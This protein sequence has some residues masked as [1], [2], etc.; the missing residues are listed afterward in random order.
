MLKEKLNRWTIGAS[1][2]WKSLNASITFSEL[3]QNKYVSEIAA[4]NLHN[5]RVKHKIFG[6]ALSYL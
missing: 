4:V 3:Q 6:T 2:N 1:V 5:E